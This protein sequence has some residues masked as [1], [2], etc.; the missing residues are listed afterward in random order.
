QLELYERNLLQHRDM[1][2]VIQTAVEEA[3]QEKA[4]EIAKIMLRNNE[5]NE[6]IAMYTGLTTQ[7]IE[8]LATELKKQ[9]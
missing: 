8:Q 9:S 5:A 3:T 6:K 1:K 2:A 7:Q 4:I